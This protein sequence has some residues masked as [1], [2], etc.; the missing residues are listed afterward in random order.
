LILAGCGSS[1]TIF[2]VP[3]DNALVKGS[4]QSIRQVCPGL[5]AYSSELTNIKVQNNIR[6]TIAFDIPAPAK[7]PPA[8]MAGGQS[9]FL[10]LGADGKQVIIEKDACKAVCLNRAQ[11]PDGQMVLSLD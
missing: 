8:F 6:T 2:E 7:M 9:C 4:L 3:T 1:D 11:V 5:D 10:E